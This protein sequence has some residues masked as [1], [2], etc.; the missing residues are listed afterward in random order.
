M[1]TKI[2]KTVLAIGF[3][4]LLLSTT[5]ISGICGKTE[6]IKSEIPA[7]GFIAINDTITK[8][9][10]EISESDKVDLADQ[11]DS[12]ADT[13]NKF[14]DG[15][16]EKAILH[17]EIAITITKLEAIFGISIS[18]EDEADLKE[19]L[20]DEETIVSKGGR[21]I[22]FHPIVSA[23]YGI[24]WIPVYPFD[25]FAGFLLRPIFLIYFAGATAAFYIR[26]LPPNLRLKTVAGLHTLIITNGFLGI[27]IS[28]GKGV[29]L[30]T[31]LLAG[32]A[33]RVRGSP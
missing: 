33:A 32:V 17:E 13:L 30:K 1:E 2:M 8:I 18:E 9:D 31:T 7:I 25:S 14:H 28:L 16:V 24:S 19:Y 27:H 26:I 22:P 11:F 4:A 5:L 21:S 15:T 12:L 20:V 23:G 29:L 10:K 6:T 3:V